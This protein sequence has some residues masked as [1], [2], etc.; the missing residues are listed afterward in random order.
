MTEQ[1]QT[2]LKPYLAFDARG[3]N[4]DGTQAGTRVKAI[5]A[6]EDS[7]E[8]RQVLA[9]WQAPEWRYY[10]NPIYNGEF[11]TRIVLIY[12]FL[13]V[14]IEGERLQHLLA[15]IRKKT[16][17][18]IQDFHPDEFEEPEPS[19]TVIR[20]IKVNVR[21]GDEEEIIETMPKNREAELIEYAED[22]Q[23]PVRQLSEK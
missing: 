13:I 6:P 20:K 9:P 17:I 7:L 15:A 12:S 8:I 18:Y 22:G 23:P 21:K 2:R 10:Q 4:E 1:T 11:P 3:K 19:Q 14:E 5:N 16:C